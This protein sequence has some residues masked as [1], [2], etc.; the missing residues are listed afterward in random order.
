MTKQIK[1]IKPV[2]KSALK[3]WAVYF[4]SGFSIIV[5]RNKKEAEAKFDK[6]QKGQVEIV[7]TEKILSPINKRSNKGIL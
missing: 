5:A 3:N 1:P 2:R 4:K 6:Q 7:K